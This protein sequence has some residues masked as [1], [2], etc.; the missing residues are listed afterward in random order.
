MIWKRDAEGVLVWANRA[1]IELSEALHPQG[2]DDIRPWPPKEVFQDTAVPAGS[3][4]II[5]MHRIDMPGHD[6]PIW[7][8]ITSLKRD[9]ETIYF[10]IDASAVVFAQDAQRSFVQTLTKTFAQLSVGLA[11]FDADRRLVLFNPALVDLTELPSDFLIGRPPLYSFLDRLRDANMIPE[12]KD[13]SS[14]RDRMVALENAAEAGSYHETWL[15]STGQ[16]FRETGKP[17]PNG[18]IAFLFEDISD[19]VSL[20]RKFRSQIDTCTAIIDNV[21]VGVAVFSA[22]GS[23]MMAN[24]SY[25]NLWGSEPEDII[26]S[27][28]VLDELATWEAASAPSAVWIKLRDIFTKSV[29]EPQWSGNFWLDGNVELEFQYTP[30]PDG[31]H[32]VTFQTSS[33]DTDELEPLETIEFKEQ[34]TAAR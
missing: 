6:K 32:M 27:G 34:R 33:H 31:H 18:A 5:D 30:L 17:H 22:S 4:P 11:I 15:L 26:G 24:K 8:E 1:Y 29:S 3:A 25:R 14:W 28:D 10:A 2:P 7:F 23:L 21:P 12:P 16:T 19:E 20:N 9:T 13:Y